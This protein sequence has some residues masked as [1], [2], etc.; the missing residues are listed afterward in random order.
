[1]NYGIHACKMMTNKTSLQKYVHKINRPITRYDSILSAEQKVLYVYGSMHSYYTVV[2]L[3]F[4]VIS[5]T[6]QIYNS[7]AN[8]Y[9]ICILYFDE[10]LATDFTSL[11]GLTVFKCLHSTRFLRIKVYYLF[12]FGSRHCNWHIFQC[13]EI[14]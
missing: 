4:F 3:F 6:W 9:N 8:N 13:A 5:P 10:I 14:L 12:A 7:N 1:M 11:H 2:F